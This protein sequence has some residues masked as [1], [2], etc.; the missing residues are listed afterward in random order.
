MR[1]PATP[2]WGAPWCW[3]WVNPRHSW[4]MVLGAVPRHSWL[5]S[6]GCGGGRFRG[7]VGEFPVL[8]V[9]V[10]RRVLV[11]ALCVC[12]GC[13]G[14]AVSAVC[15]GTCVACGGWFPWLGL[16]AGVGVGVAGVCCGWFLATPGGG[17]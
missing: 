6:V 17:S 13:L 5:G 16:A 14:V 8:C 1:S 10:A 4:L 2:G 9:F 7:V 15:V 3:W 11:C 12:G